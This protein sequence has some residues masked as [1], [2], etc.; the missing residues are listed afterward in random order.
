MSDNI[1][2]LGV[3][4]LGRGTAIARELFTIPGTRLVAACDHNPEILE[5]GYKELSELSGYDIIKLSDYDELLKCDIDAVIVATEAIYH[6]PVVKK[7]MDAGKHVLSE[8]PSVNS[9]EEARILKECCNAHPELIYMA[10]ENCCFW[11]FIETWKKMHAQGLFGEI[12]YAEAEYLHAMDP[13]EFAPDNYPPGHWRTVNP[14]VKYLTHELGP[15][16]YIMNDKCVS[17]SGMEADTIYNPYFPNIKSTGVALIKTEKGAVIRILVSFGAYT[18]Y[19]HNFRICGTKGAIETGRLQVVDD[20]YSYANLQSIPGTFSKKIEIPVN[21]AY[22]GESKEGHG[23]ADH[24]MVEEFI[25][26]LKTGEK[27]QLDVDFAI[28]MSL[29]GVLAHES[30]VNGGTAI[31]IP[32]F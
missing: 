4:G 30:A 18:S 7:A 19:D 22:D 26:C 2:K 28:N 14:A 21:S 32:R 9:V 25:R 24:K 20:A 1:I 27:P 12:S 6:V 5:K 10:A 17:V 29:P 13:E 16:L 15:L 23:G 31:E 8:I 11:A 3:V